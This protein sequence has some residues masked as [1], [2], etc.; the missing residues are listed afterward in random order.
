MGKMIVGA[1]IVNRKKIGKKRYKWYIPKGFRHKIEKGNVVLVKTGEG[2]N[3]KFSPVI[4][5]DV[6]DN[7]KYLYEPVIKIL[8]KNSEKH[9][10]NKLFK[11]KEV[12]KKRGKFSDEEKEMIRACRS[13]G[14]TLK[15]IS[16]MYSC[17]IS[18]I[19]KIIKK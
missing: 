1:H 6:V 9:I 14:K 4:V 15:V 10:D 13:E 16:E 12:S 19:H 7:D 17:S 11:K 2:E 3:K 18:T 5:L 8:S